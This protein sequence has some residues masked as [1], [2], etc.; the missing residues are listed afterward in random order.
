MATY[1]PNSCIF[2]SLYIPQL[3]SPHISTRILAFPWRVALLLLVSFTCS[4]LTRPQGS[5]QMPPV[6][7]VVPTS[8]RDLLP[9]LNVCDTFLVPLLVIPDIRC[10]VVQLFIYLFTLLQPLLSSLSSEGKSDVV[11]CLRSSQDHA[12]QKADV[13]EQQK[14]KLQMTQEDIRGAFDLTQIRKFTSCP[15][16]SPPP[17]PNTDQGCLGLPISQVE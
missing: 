1:W 17:S 3:S 12:C 11:F 6:H 13:N 10:L 9:P 4:Y 2:C 15:S 5:A 8:R 14:Q 16:H 7:V